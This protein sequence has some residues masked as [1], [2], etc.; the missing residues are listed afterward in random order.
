MSFE[1]AYTEEVE[2]REEAPMDFDG[3]APKKKKVVKKHEIAFST[4]TSSL[5]PAVVEKLKEQEAQMHA[6]DKYVMDTEV[7]SLYE[8]SSGRWLW[9]QIGPQECARGIC[10]R[11][12][13]QA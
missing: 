2:E 8:C 1:S 13:W 9:L 6:V 4:T 5:D 12:A 7:G 10:L 11:R 3:E